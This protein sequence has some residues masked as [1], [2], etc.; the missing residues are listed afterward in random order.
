M[1]LKYSKSGTP[2]IEFDNAKLIFGDS[3]KNE[4]GYRWFCLSGIQTT[5]SKKNKNSSKYHYSDIVPVTLNGV[6]KDSKGFF[7]KGFK[8]VKDK[9]NKYVDNEVFPYKN[10]TLLEQELNNGREL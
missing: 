3:T 9:I 6:C 8:K 2:Y 1:I 10:L 4:I 5:K 7:G